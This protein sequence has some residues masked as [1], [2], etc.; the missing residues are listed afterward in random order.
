MAYVKILFS[1]FHKYT[2]DWPL[3]D[4]VFWYNILIKGTYI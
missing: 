2:L 4:M 3:L 1:A